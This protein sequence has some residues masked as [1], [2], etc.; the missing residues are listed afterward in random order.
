MKRIFTVLALFATIV[1]AATS[2]AKT[3]RATEITP[4]MLAQLKSNDALVVEF[5]QG[6][7]LPVNI[8]AVGDL[9]ETAGSGSTVVTV[10]RNFWLMLQN[11]DV[12]ISLDGSTY[13]PIKEVLT[14]SLSADAEASQPGSPANLINVV[15]ATY[16]K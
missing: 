2:E 3:V 4:G 6:D 7:Q 9:I 14:G 8:S 15:F 5:R 13:K 16:L 12:Q 1:A 11:N 10:K